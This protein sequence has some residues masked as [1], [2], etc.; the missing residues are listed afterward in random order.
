[1]RLNLLKE[2][3]GLKGSWKITEIDQ[4]GNRK[5]VFQ[6]DSVICVGLTETIQRLMT[7]NGTADD[8]KERRK[9]TS[10]AKLH[11]K[12][13]QSKGKFCNPKQLRF[14]GTNKAVRGKNR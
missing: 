10:M 12:L 4:A 7:G 1:M 8:T 11:D 5:V 3:I 6:K 2:K 13:Q 9:T 14:H